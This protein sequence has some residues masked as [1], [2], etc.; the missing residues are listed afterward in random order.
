M[1]GVSPATVK[2]GWNPTKL[3]LYYEVCNADHHHIKPCGAAGGRIVQTVAVPVDAFGSSSEGYA[4][5]R[6]GIVFSP[7][8]GG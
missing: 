3:W 4:D 5:A 6:E 2:R 8:W 1:L 7:S